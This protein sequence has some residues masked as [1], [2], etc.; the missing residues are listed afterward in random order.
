ML[1]RSV[2]NRYCC[3]NIIMQYT[4]NITFKCVANRN[5]LYEIITGSKSVSSAV[6]YCL[7]ISSSADLGRVSLRLT[8]VLSPS[9]SGALCIIPSREKMSKKKENA[10]Y[11]T[12][13]ESELCWV[14]SRW[15]DD[16]Y[17]T[18]QTR[19]SCRLNA[20]R[21]AAT[22]PAGPN[23]ISCVAAAATAAARVILLHHFHG[24]PA[25]P[26][27]AFPHES[28][29]KSWANFYLFFGLFRTARELRMCVYS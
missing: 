29:G 15:N 16:K 12:A 1:I 19:S 18:Q 17:I 26:A 27:H 25:E 10:Y 20:E 14:W 11:Y 4:H 28:K 24:T 23:D 3:I 13:R 8:K 5:P 22:T 9:S 7:N 21:A 6:Y 2:L